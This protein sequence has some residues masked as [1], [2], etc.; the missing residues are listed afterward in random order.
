[1]R[2]KFD[3]PTDFPVRGTPGGY[4]DWWDG[5]D[6]AVVTRARV[7]AAMHELWA[8]MVREGERWRRELADTSRPRWQKRAAGG[9]RRG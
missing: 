9:A 7:E 6:E 3:P 1:M 2:S 5:P 8:D 4:R